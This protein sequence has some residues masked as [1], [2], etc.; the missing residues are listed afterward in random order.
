MGRRI[1]WWLWTIIGVGTLTGIVA[2][3]GGFDEVPIEALPEVALGEPFP[4]N[5]VAVQV[6]D[7]HLARTAPIT[8]YDAP[9][10]QIYLVVEATV[11]NTTAAPNI[12]VNRAVRVLVE[13]VVSGNDAPYNVVDLSTG[14][15]VPF[16]QPGLPV[17]IAFLWAI[18][19]ARL[20]PGDEIIVGIFERYDMVDDPRFDDSKTDPVPIVRLVESIGAFR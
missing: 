19:D 7:I 4:G 5:E 15:G 18:D 8:E 3:L 1:P 17:R 13:G 10:G 14:D 12:F 6:D 2:L 9:D 16:L 11:E 20:E